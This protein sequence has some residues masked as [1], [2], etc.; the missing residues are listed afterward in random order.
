MRPSLNVDH[1]LVHATHAGRMH[2][3]SEYRVN[4]RNSKYMHAGMDIPLDVPEWLFTCRPT[5][6]SWK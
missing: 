4:V 6:C 3:C 5:V 1:E 2:E